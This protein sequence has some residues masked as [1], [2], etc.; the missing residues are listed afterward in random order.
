[1]SESWFLAELR[2]VGALRTGHFLLASGRHSD[3]YVEK[4]DLL[5][6]PVATQEACRRL[7]GL[8]SELADVDLVVGPTTGGILLAFEVARQLALPAAYAERIAEGASERDFKRGTLIAPGTRVLLVD[9]VLTTGGSVRETL[10]ALAA[11]G[12]DVRAIG[13]LVD[14][15]GG[16]VDFGVPLR[17]LVTLDIASF[18]PQECPL[19]RE[20]V[21]LTKPGSTAQPAA[22]R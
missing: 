7:I 19:C 9:D 15:S 17:S 21:P 3:Q 22:P 10:A 4:F 16:S 1:M 6:Q 20:G 5:R 13:L 12:A 18:T 2:R 8:L 14:R 11:R